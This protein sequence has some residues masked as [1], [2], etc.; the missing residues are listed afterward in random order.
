MPQSVSPA[1]PTEPGCFGAV[2]TAIHSGRRGRR[3][4]FAGG[5]PTGT[6]ELGPNKRP[7]PPMLCSNQAARKRI[8]AGQGLSGPQRRSWRSTCWP[9][10]RTHWRW[11]VRR[12]GV[13]RQDKPVAGYCSG[14]CA[15]NG[16]QVSMRRASEGRRRL[17]PTAAACSWI[18]AP[19]DVE[20]TDSSAAEH[21]GRPVAD[22]PLGRVG[23]MEAHGPGRRR[24]QLGKRSPRF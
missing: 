17:P 19:D 13:G 5:L 15:T 9:G 24:A 8:A 7:A 10:R 23:S 4:S 2:T 21:R 6:D 1:L 22:G 11:P 3:W 16:P 18:T 20:I 14:S 12:R